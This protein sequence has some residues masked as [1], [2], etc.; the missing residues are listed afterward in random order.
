[1]F[2]AYTD[3]ARQTVF[4]ARVEAVER[5][6]VVI[7]TEHLLCGLMRCNARPLLVVLGDLGVAMTDLRDAI[8]HNLP[9]KVQGPLPEV[10]VPL[11]PG[12]MR[13]L[14]L[15]ADEARR[16]QDGYL[17]TEHILAGLVQEPDGLG[18]TILSRKGVTLALVRTVAQRLRAARR[19]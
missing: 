2:E 5:G 9:P 6:G 8:E 7:S 13:V 11:A 12:A 10:D 18:G 4:Y 19:G 16:N 14:E 15:A 1:V 3:P 17:G